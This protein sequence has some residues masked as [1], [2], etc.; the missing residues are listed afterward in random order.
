MFPFMASYNGN[1]NPG[2]QHANL[3]ELYAQ[4]WYLL[5]NLRQENLKATDLLRKLPT[6]EESLTQSQTSTIRRRLRKQIKW[7]MYR[8]NEATC[9]EKTIL[10]RMNQLTQEIASLERQNQIK[11]YQRRYQSDLGSLGISSYDVQHVGM[12]Q[13]TSQNHFFEHPFF[14]RWTPQQPYEPGEVSWWQEFRD[15]V[16]EMPSE[17]FTPISPQSTRC[18][19]NFSEVNAKVELLA[20]TISHASRQRQRSLS[21]SSLN[22]KSIASKMAPV[23]HSTMKRCST[24]CSGDI[25]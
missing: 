2:L 1:F 25:N 16:S 21:M 18:S 12:L 6:L 5:S 11:M 4:R 15:C 17:I 19:R 3:E 23:S 20:P 10:I 8:I 24:W 14:H 22:V 9:Q 7:V 13:V